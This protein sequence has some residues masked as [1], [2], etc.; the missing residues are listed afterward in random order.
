MFDYPKRKHPRLKRYD[1]STPG[2]Y[3]VTICTEG[4]RPLLSAV[5]QNET[6][7]SKYGHCV[8]TNLLSLPVRYPFLEIRKYAIMPNHIHAILVMKSGTEYD[9]KRFPIT[10]IICAYKSL[11]AND[12]HRFGMKEKLFQTSFYEHVIRDRDEYAD[13]EKYIADNPLKWREDEF[14][15]E[16]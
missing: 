11:T 6:V 5:R 12:C 2:A 7:L 3:F 16:S 9:G 15:S 1:Y 13:V 14:Y 8:E 10:A 4:K